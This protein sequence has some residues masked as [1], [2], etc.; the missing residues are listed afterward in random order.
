MINIININ[1]RKL[2]Q[3]DLYPGI[4]HDFQRFQETKRAFRVS[5]ESLVLQ[6]TFFVDEWDKSKKERVVKSLQECI[7]NGGTVI[8]GFLDNTLIAFAN[9]QSQF[10]GSVNQYLELP[11]FRY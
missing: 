3:S 11:Y 4:L 7:S 10:F 5:G 6:D 9:I 2:S 8:G 1:F